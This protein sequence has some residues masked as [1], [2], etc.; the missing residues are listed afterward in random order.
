MKRLRGV[1]S[2]TTGVPVD[3]RLSGSGATSKTQRRPYFSST[4]NWTK[5]F[6][7]LS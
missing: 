7:S 4:A 2:V 1:M 6:A 5:E 3:Q